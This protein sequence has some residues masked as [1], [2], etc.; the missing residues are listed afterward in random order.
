MGRWVNR[1]TDT[2]L[3]ES[4]VEGARLTAYREGFIRMEADGR[5]AVFSALKS[6]PHPGKDLN[7][8]LP[9]ETYLDLDW[10]VWA[11]IAGSF[12]MQKTR[13]RSMRE[14]ELPL[15]EEHLMTE[16]DQEK[17]LMLT[18]GREVE[19]DLIQRQ[20]FRTVEEEIHLHMNRKWRSVAIDRYYEGKSRRTV[21][22]EREMS[23]ESMRA[24][25]YRIRHHIRKRLEKR[26][27]L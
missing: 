2:P 3:A 14:H 15:L 26:H 17:G 22:A 5:V 4:A 23:M 16:E 18:G 13:R 1:E 19:E 27:L 12:H 10:R 11:V 8:H 20:I 24:L 25:E 6:P 7:L 21:A 9:M